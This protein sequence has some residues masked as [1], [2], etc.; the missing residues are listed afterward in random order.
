MGRKK[1]SRKVL[2]E[3]FR[4]IYEAFRIGLCAQ[5]IAIFAT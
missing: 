1:G 5:N 3:S 4:I 2:K